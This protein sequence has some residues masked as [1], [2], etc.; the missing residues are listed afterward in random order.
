MKTSLTK[1]M[2]EREK[3]EFKAQFINSYPVRSK[4]IEV[5]EEKIKGIYKEMLEEDISS[6]PSWPIS[7]A[8]KLAEVRALR[9]II[10]LLEN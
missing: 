8:S 4:Y 9:K 6:S 5:L 3:E 1:G 7:Q 10:S 2:D